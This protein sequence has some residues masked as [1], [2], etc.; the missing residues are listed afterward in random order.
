MPPGSLLIPNSLSVS[1]QTIAKGACLCTVAR[2]LSHNVNQGSYHCFSVR[3]FQY[4]SEHPTKAF[5]A[6]LRILSSSRRAAVDS[7]IGLQTAL[8]KKAKYVLP[9]WRRCTLE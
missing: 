5:V 6:I 4:S 8:L 7:E 2:E 9:I 1:D 3:K